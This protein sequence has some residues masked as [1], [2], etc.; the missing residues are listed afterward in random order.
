MGEE[1]ES[2]KSEKE[3]EDLEQHVGKKV[4]TP[5]GKVGKIS[6]VEG[7]LCYVVLDKEEDSAEAKEDDSKKKKGSDDESEA[8]GSD[9]DDGSEAKD[10]GHLSGVKSP[11]KSKRRQR[12]RSSS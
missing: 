11:S 12:A 8:K 6:R 7:D 3:D 9:N 2:D 4:K 10:E 1:E 5:S